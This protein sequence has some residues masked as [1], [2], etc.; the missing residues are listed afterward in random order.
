M[1][2]E[3]ILKIQVRSFTLFHQTS[4]HL[5]HFHLLIFKLFTSYAVLCLV[6]FFLFLSCLCAISDKVSSFLL[7][8]LPHFNNSSYLQRNLSLFCVGSWDCL[9]M[10]KCVL[11]VNIH[12]DGCKS[13]VKKILQKIDGMYASISPC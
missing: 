11:R 3:E 6:F 8:L 2:K 9:N 4:L 5:S 12:C 1:S 13:K 7:L 10:Q